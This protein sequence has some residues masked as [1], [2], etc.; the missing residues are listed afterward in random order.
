[1]NLFGK[2]FKKKDDPVSSY[3]DF[4]NWFSKNSKKF[5]AVVKNHNRIEHDFFD[6]LSPKLDELKDGFWYLTGM[7]DDDTVELVITADGAIKNFVFVEELIEAA[8]TI[9]NWKFTALKPAL[10]IENVKIHMSGYDFDKMTLQFYPNENPGYPDEIDIT[11]THNKLTEDNRPDILRG[12]YIF[13]DNYLGELNFAANVD[14][15][16]IIGENEAKKELIPIEKLKDYLAWRQK[17]FVEKYEGVR[18]QTGEDEHS[19]METALESG[20]ILIGTINTGLL[21]WD[22]KA[23]HPWILTVTIPYDGENNNGMPD[24]STYQALDAISTILS[25]KL[26]DHEGYLNI[27]RETGNGER[28]IY[29]ACKDFRKPSK[30]MYTLQQENQGQFKISYKFFKDKYWKTFD[31]LNPLSPENIAANM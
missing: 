12:I 10:N 26:K 21:Q 31:R 6:K 29:Y 7:Y 3:A 17:E 18:H 16:E 20:R 27:G 30:T 14:T 2:I 9:P 4:W 1:M 22:Q 28:E 11:I 5:Y 24:D 25:D 15:L 19:I 23:S 8:P 13:L